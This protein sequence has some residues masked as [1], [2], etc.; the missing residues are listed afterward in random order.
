M[1]NLTIDHGQR[2]TSFL[3]KEWDA[4]GTT[5]GAWCREAGLAD[6]TV[7]RWGQGVEPDMRNLRMVA[8]GLGRRLVDVLLAAGYLS[9][10]DVGGHVPELSSRIDFETALLIATGI[11]DEERAAHLKLRE[12]YQLVE[13]GRA[14]RV[15]VR[16][17]GS[18]KD[19]STKVTP[20]RK[21]ATRGSRSR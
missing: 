4:A 5:R 1:G 13:S 3:Q 17:G 11:S 20:I 14:S 2:L 19:G 12:A 9:P 21:P 8:Q 6:S 15:T 10:D 16:G 18:K 7:M